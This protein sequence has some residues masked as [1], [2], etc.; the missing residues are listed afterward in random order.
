MLHACDACVSLRRA[1]WGDAVLIYQRHKRLPCNQR[2]QH[3]APC[4]GVSIG[5]ILMHP[6]RAQRSTLTTACHT[7]SLSVFCRRGWPIPS[8][9]GWFV[10]VSPSW[11]AT[12]ICT[13]GRLSAAS[14]S[15][16]AQARPALCTP[17]NPCDPLVPPRTHSPA[18]RHPKAG[19]ADAA[20]RHQ[21]VSSRR[22]AVL[23]V[24]SSASCWRC[25][26][27]KVPASEERLRWRHQLT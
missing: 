26:S 19:T 7:F 9:E 17:R 12:C 27:I 1:C 2:P 13:A 18:D 11:I 5:H 21:H 3:V 6:W 4:S 23:C 8:I 22:R 10:L 16:C 25:R 20:G 14:R 24:R 15:A